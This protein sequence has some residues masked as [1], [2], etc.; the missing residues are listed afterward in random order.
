[1]ARANKRASWIVFTAVPSN[2]RNSI[3]IEVTNE[4]QRVSQIR[5]KWLKNNISSTKAIFMDE[6]LSSS[7]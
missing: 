1:M 2:T 7:E 6:Y 3:G 4:N 5:V